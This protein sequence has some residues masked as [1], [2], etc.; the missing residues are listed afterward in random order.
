MGRNMPAS[1]TWLRTAL[2]NA[3]QARLDGENRAIAK[4]EPFSNRGLRK[5]G[6]IQTE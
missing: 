1:V 6:K 3:K 5:N 2:N 4:T